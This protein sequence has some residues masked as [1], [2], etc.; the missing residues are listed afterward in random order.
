MMV[1][2]DEGVGRWRRE[3]E[4]AP[5]EEKRGGSRAITLQPVV[6]LPRCHRGRRR[7]E[8]AREWEVHGLWV[9]VAEKRRRREGARSEE[10]EAHEEEKP[11]TSLITVSVAGCCRQSAS[12]HRVVVTVLQHR[13]ST[14]SRRVSMVSPKNHH[15]FCP[16][17]VSLGFAAFHGETELILP[18]SPCVDVA[19]VTTTDSNAI[20]A[21][22]VAVGPSEFLAAVGAAAESARDCDCSILFLLIELS[23]LPVAIKTISAIAEVSRPAIEAAVYFGRRGMILVT[24]LVYGFNFRGI[25]NERDEKK[26]NEDFL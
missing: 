20:A 22:A 5:A 26:D 12:Y 14:S 23:G 7:R 2:R 10:R 4:S 3:K 17:P 18:P 11:A 15:Y 1:I 24:P 25:V 21:V 19:A 16:A 8:I 13:R 6:P 9:T